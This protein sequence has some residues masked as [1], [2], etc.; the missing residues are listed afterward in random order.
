MELVN[1]KKV[2]NELVRIKNFGRFSKKTE[3]E[4]VDLFLFG[5]SHRDIPLKPDLPQ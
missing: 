4:S 5:G 1:L 3:A 2:N